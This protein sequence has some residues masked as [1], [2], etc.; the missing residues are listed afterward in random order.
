LLGHFRRLSPAPEVYDGL[1]AHARLGRS[2]EPVPFPKEAAA[3][4][5]QLALWKIALLAQL[6]AQP[7]LYRLH[8]LETETLE[9]SS[10]RVFVDPECP[11]CGGG[12]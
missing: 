7:A 6:E 5:V 1:L 3:I 11:E 8:V 9:V 12:A 10:H 4:L 2:V